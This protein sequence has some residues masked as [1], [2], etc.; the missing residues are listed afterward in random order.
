MFDWAGYLDVADRLLAEAPDEAALRS[1]ISRA[2][3]AAYHAAAAFVAAS[4]LLTQRH[5]HRR[6]WDALAS[7]FDPARS[8]IGTRGDQLRQIRNDADY[9]DRMPGNLEIRA[10]D[11]VAEGRSLVEAIR[12]LP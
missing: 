1:A 9:R 2:Y 3:Y 12:Q 7:D 8:S 5:T 11:A 10:R 4:G 6:V